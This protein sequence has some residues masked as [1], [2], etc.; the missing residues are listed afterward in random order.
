MAS[1]AA[2]HVFTRA[3]QARKLALGL[4]VA[5]AQDS[6]DPSPE[7]LDSAI[8]FAPVGNLVP[9]G[10]AAL[11]RRGTLA[12]AGIYPTDIPALNY[13]AHL[14]QRRTLRSVPSNTR[15]AAEG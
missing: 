5:S 4:G 15:G 10:L 14:L 9:P 7:P 3:P 1:G 8:L 6:F 12:V 11:D 13:V 2:V